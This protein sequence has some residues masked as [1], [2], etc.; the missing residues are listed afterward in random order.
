MTPVGH[1]AVSWLTARPLP[2]KARF[3]LVAGGLL[4]DVDFALVLMPGFNDLH[5]NATHSL[6]FAALLG[7]L[8]AVV[9]RRARWMAGAAVLFGALLHIQIDA[10]LDSNPSNGIGVALFWPFS[11]WMYSPFNLLS[12]GC[13]GWDRPL[14]ALACTGPMLL[15]ELPFWLL[16]GFLF[17]RSRRID[18][19]PIP[20]G[21]RK[22]PLNSG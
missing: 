5:R 20:S 11:A 15:W 10:V 1:L 16:A 13:P 17:V 3:W 6:A 2:V 4:P 7:L 19:A 12:A 18:P 9:S 21:D 14:V 22:R 8:A